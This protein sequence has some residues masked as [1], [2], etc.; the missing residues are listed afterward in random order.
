MKAKNR[1]YF[2]I[3]G[4]VLFTLLIINQVYGYYQVHALTSQYSATLTSNM[5][6]QARELS[7]DAPKGA[8]GVGATTS[9]APDSKLSSFGKQAPPASP[10]AMTPS[11]TS[12]ALQKLKADLASTTEQLMQAQS[13][14]S[15]IVESLALCAG[16]EPMGDRLDCYDRIPRHDKRADG[17]KEPQN[18]PWAIRKTISPLD[19]STSI[20]LTVSARETFKSYGEKAVQPFFSISCDMNNATAMFSTGQ[21]FS[22]GTHFLETR[23]GKNKSSKRGWRMDKHGKSA[24]LEMHTRDFIGQLMATDRLAIQIGAPGEP[25]SVL[26]FDLSG[27]AEENGDLKKYCGV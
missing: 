1:S 23:I 2:F 14:R 22:Q 26:T 25:N 7:S 17:R 8:T 10:P 11:D 13:D 9:L 5:Q 27:L 15:R 4:G 16:V 19:D 21:Y 12:L 6:Q 18:R 20:S 3:S 24:Y